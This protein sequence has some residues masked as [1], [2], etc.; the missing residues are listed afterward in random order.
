MKRPS[1]EACA[2]LAA[3]IDAYVAK[4]DTAL[5]DELER[6]GYTNVDDIL[7]GAAKI[8]DAVAKAL[9]KSSEAIAASVSQAVNLEI[10]RQF[11]LPGVMMSDALA[12]QIA[13]IIIEQFAQYMPRLVLGFSTQIDAQV[14]I[15]Q[16]SAVS[17]RFMQSWGPRLGQLMKLNQYADIEKLITDGMQNGLGVQELATQIKNAGIRNTRWKARRVALTEMLRCSSVAAQDAMTQSPA[18]AGKRW[19][20]TGAKYS[21]PRENHLAINGQE[22]PKDQPFE[23]LGRDG[24]MYYPM[25]PRDPILP[26]GESVNCHCLAQPIAAPEVFA[27]PPEERQRLA[28]QAREQVDATRDQWMAEATER[29]KAE[30][31]AWRARQ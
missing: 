15:Q 5:A 29:A 2:A 24:V 4:A 8:E 6:A 21:V 20:H 26:A 12:E 18:C 13:S 7:A 23:L 17:T 9:D 31:E 30:S 1:H 16:M 3:A 25:Y 10:W 19:V 22:V 14:P 11:I 27:L 28:E